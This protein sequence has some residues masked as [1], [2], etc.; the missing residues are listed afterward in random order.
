M[1]LPQSQYKSNLFTNGGEF[2]IS[3]TGEIYS[4]YYFETYKNERYTGKSPQDGTPQL[5]LPLVEQTN[6]PNNSVTPERVEIS[7]SPNMEYSHTAKPRLIPQPNPTQPTPDD[8]VNGL[9]TR[10][11]CKKNNELKYMEIDQPTYTKLKSQD[12][13]VAW[14]LYTPTSIQWYIAGEIEKVYNVNKSIVNLVEVEEKWYGFSQYF[15]QD[16][17][18][19]FAV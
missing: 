11:F 14:D 18:K 4:G 10:Y 16:Y 6:L 17:A 12:T 3:T 7:I 8:Y 15:K 1:Y 5:L 19:Y 2:K 9:F 13:T